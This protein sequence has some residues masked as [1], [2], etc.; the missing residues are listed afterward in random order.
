MDGSEIEVLLLDG[1]P[2]K[3]EDRI[4]RGYYLPVV[5]VAVVPSLFVV[6]TITTVETEK[7]VCSAIRKIERMLQDEVW[8]A[9][10]VVAAGVTGVLVALEV[11]GKGGVVRGYWAQNAPRSD[12]AV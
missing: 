1:T 3:L 11:A 6:V 2:L 8:E 5:N 7:S 4:C 10:V 9:T 12:V